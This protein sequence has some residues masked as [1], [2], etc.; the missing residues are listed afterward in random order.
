MEYFTRVIRGMGA[1]KEGILE[2]IGLQDLMLS[3][4][5]FD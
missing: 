2:A 3:I 4:F 5:E 1:V